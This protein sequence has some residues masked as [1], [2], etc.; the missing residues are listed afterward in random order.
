M[1]S[2]YRYVQPI[3]LASTMILALFTGSASAL[4]VRD[5]NLDEEGAVIVVNHRKGA[6]LHLDYVGTEL[7]SS[8]RVAIKA[9]HKGLKL[10]PKSCTFK[11]Q[12]NSC[13]LTLKYVARDKPIYGNQTLRITEA[14]GKP[15][16]PAASVK[17]VVG[18]KSS[19]APPMV[20]WV[21]HGHW[22]API[23][24]GGVFLQNGTD[25]TRTY[26]G[27]IQNRYDWLDSKDTVIT[28][29]INLPP[30]TIC[31]LDEYTLP[32]NTYNRNNGLSFWSTTKSAG[33]LEGNWIHDITDSNRH[34]HNNFYV[35]YDTKHISTCSAMGEDDC[36]GTRW[37]SWTVG[38]FNMS[39]Q[40][41]YDP[42]KKLVF[43]PGTERILQN[44]AWN[45]GDS[46]YFDGDAWQNNNVA[47]I[48][49]QG[50]IDGNGFDPEPLKLTQNQVLAAPPCSSFV[51]RP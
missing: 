49:I 46:I 43:L 5:F 8:L 3:R 1:K 17:F 28:S 36:A 39:D 35:K 42:D 19:E 26:Q 25:L 14:T 12:H 21:H 18:M 23:Q 13:E 45:S 9:E 29:A 7:S 16:A 20:R 32:T 34:N 22:G 33:L 47:L 44:N 4:E 51:D 48:L 50:A 37:A 30:K 38:L 2:A 27:N 15:D 10:S 6:R 41:L 40:G 24:K 31:Y 11:R